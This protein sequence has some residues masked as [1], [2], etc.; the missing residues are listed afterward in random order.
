MEAKDNSIRRKANGKGCQEFGSWNAELFEF[1]SRKEGIK[2]NFIGLSEI[3]EVTK[4]KTGLI[5]SVFS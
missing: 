4:H 3:S 2:S 5:P 1:G